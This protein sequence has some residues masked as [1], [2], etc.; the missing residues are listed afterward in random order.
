MSFLHQSLYCGSSKNDL[1]LFIDNDEHAEKSSPSKLSAAGGLGSL[2][3]SYVVDSSEE[4]GE[5]KSGEGQ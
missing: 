2:M 5:I 3:S 1:Q 4:E